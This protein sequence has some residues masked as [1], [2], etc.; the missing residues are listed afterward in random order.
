M[1]AVDVSHLTD[2]E[3]MFFGWAIT[4]ETEDF[5]IYQL[6]HTG[7]EQIVSKRLPR[8]L[9]VDDVNDAQQMSVGG[10][11]SIPKYLLKGDPESEKG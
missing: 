7:E 3:L 9:I 11:L 6:I 5:F 1:F 8:L 10:F 4:K 2:E